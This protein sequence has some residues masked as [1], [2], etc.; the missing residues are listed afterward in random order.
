[1]TAMI[2]KRYELKYLMDRE[3]TE[4]LLESMDGRMVLD[5]Y[6]HSQINNIYLDTDNYLLARRSIERPPYKEKLRFRS[7]G[8]ADDD[9]EVFVELKKKYESVVYKRR[10]SMPL[11]EAMEWFT[12]DTDRFPHTQIGNEIDY[13]RHRYPGIC[14]AML[15]CYEREAY[16]SLDGSDLRITLDTNIRAG[17][18][19][20][21]LR[22]ISGTR[23]V[24]PDGYT[25]MEVK[26]MYGFPGWLNSALEENGIVKTSFSKYGNAYKELELGLGFED[27]YGHR[28]GCALGA[29]RLNDSDG[30][31]IQAAIG[32]QRTAM[33]GVQNME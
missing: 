27:L 21:D 33:A 1:M 10:L 12:T 31:C 20:V 4:G 13:L 3:Q 18:D 5:G 6:G 8:A 2:F 7:Y 22:N 23:R 19:S 9:S 30:V 17:T 15:L 11:S 16:R 32:E 24:M 14:P 29:A 28:R 26:T 25:L